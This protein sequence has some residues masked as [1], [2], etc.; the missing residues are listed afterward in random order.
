MTYRKEF[1]RGFAAQ[2]SPHTIDDGWSIFRNDEEG[3]EELIAVVNT[4]TTADLLLAC[5]SEAAGIAVLK[6][7]LDVVEDVGA[8][9]VLS[10]SASS[11][12]VLLIH[13][14]PDVP[15]YG[16]EDHWVLPGGKF[17]AIKDKDVS[18]TAIR[19]LEEETG[20]KADIT[21]KMTDKT[22]LSDNGKFRRW[23]FVCKTA[24]GLLDRARVVEPAKHDHVG[25]FPVN[26]LP[27]KMSDDDREAI[28]YAIGMLG[29]PKD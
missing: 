12:C 24:P 23:W 25:W 19:E 28:N 18:D 10:W 4:E 6:P 1:T 16:Y 21:Y 15:C 20:I 11:V 2:S 13:R 27:P 29:M 22:K 17:D 26:R 5:L 9:M 3:G 14:R 7:V 8:A